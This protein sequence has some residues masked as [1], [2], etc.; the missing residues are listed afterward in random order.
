MSRTAQIEQVSAL[1]DGTTAEGYIS[2]QRR[3][4]ASPLEAIRDW[5]VPDEATIVSL[6]ILIGPAHVE[7]RIPSPAPAV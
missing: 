2:F 4:L 1:A 7:A 5:V 3:D 6:T